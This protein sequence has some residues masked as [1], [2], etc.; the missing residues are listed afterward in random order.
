VLP[1]RKAWL[2]TI[3]ATLT[4]T[5]SFADRQT[6]SVLAPSV[7]KALDID[8][9]AYGWLLSAFA[10]AYLFGTPFAG[11]WIDRV[12]ARRGLVASVL[13]WSAVAALHAIVPGFGVLFVLRLALGITEGPSFPGAAQTVQRV[14]SPAD[15]ERGFGVLF[16]GSGFGAMLIGPLATLIFRHAGWRIAFLLSSVVGLL[17]IPLWIWVTRSRAVRERLD[18]ATATAAP[19]PRAALLELVLNPLIL[20]ALCGV[21]AAAPVFN[22]AL[23][24]G[25]KYL[26]STFPIGQGD[27]GWLVLLPPIMF[28]LGAVL[29]GDRASRQR[30][31][32]GPPPRALYA[33]GIAL[34]PGDLAA[35]RVPVAVDVHHGDRDGRRRRAVHAHHLGP[36]GAHAAGERLVRRRDHG[37]CA[38]AGADHLQPA[39]RPPRRQARQLRRGR[40][41]PR[42]VGDPRQPGLAAVAPAGP[43]RR[44]RARRSHRRL[45]AGRCAVVEDLERRAR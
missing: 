29:F 42:G 8:N 24:W 15:R 30:R 22:F 21:F 11:W 6:L 39:D 35:G 23:L 28:D 45:N 2:V 41:H 31:P 12:G 1:R 17:W 44:A 33:V 3:V 40:H 43:L 18:V 13:A 20:R 37:R 34:A 36:A 5:V 7:T 10:F 32:G 26:T 4:M 27:I 9:E 38:V 25:A 14:M 16:T 19:E